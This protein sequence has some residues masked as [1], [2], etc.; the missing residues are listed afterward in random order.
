[1]SY[2]TS[3]RV[4]RFVIHETGTYNE[5]FRRPYISQLT[6]QGL[7]QILENATQAPRINA[8]I[9]SGL[10]SQVVAPAPEYESQIVIP[11][12]WSERR[13]RFML[14]LEV[15]YK[16]G[17]VIQE[18][19]TGWSETPAES[20][21][22]YGTLDPNTI[23]RVNT[24]MH[25]RQQVMHTPLGAQTQSSISDCSHV[26]SDG[27]WSGIHTREKQITMRPSDIFSKI[28]VSGVEKELASDGSY[29]ASTTLS[30]M[31]SKS[32]R[33]NGIATNYIA[34]IVR[35]YS[36]ADAQMGIGEDPIGNT[37][38]LSIAQSYV[39]ENSAARDPFLDIIAGMKGGPVS[40][41]FTL[42]DL[43]RVD[44]NADAN[45]VYIKMG[46]T[47]M[48]SAHMAG[49]TQHWAGSDIHTHIATIL[50][51][52]VPSI[53]MNH[54]ITKIAF[55]T[56]NTDFTGRID[57]RIADIDG[58]VSNMDM[59]QPAQ[60][61]LG[62]LENEILKDLS[63]NEIGFGI[64]MQVDL[65]GET[66]IKINVNGEEID[67]VTPSFCDAMFTPVLTTNNLLAANLANDFNSLM[68]NITDYKNNHSYS[69]IQTDVGLNYR[70]LL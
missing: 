43:Q 14:H 44:P 19:I 10:S 41:V 24:T 70:S 67:Y 36:D 56:T 22:I 29:D 11:N 4:V 2:A 55:V 54:L 15:Q 59:S 69:G 28:I 35:S 7:S 12:G 64:Q 38:A 30:N 63:I 46:M 62:K 5:Q 33:T 20:V 60:A 17:G 50:S 9:F 23:F 65:L 61:F 47:E 27:N 53:M 49:Q 18:I 34:D 3:I 13:F 57:T 8:G 52:S 51:N 48:S 42:A 31:A 45:T 1:M 6:P 26:L 40:D 66:W 21:S 39:R 68:T 25:I 32:K 58:F 37:D 16:T